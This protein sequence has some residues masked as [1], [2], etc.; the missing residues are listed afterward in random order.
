MH[1]VVPLPATK[2]KSPT[3]PSKVRS[4]APSVRSGGSDNTMDSTRTVRAPDTFPSMYQP[5]PLPSKKPK[6]L[7]SM[8]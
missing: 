1:N 3:T 7:R 6:D 8:S 4:V 2:K 5:P